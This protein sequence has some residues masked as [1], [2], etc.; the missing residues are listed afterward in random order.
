MTQSQ[1]KLPKECLL[2][3]IDLNSEAITEA[4]IKSFGKERFIP[5]SDI[6]DFNRE[7]VFLQNYYYS[8]QNLI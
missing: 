4:L 6:Q 7:E 3:K 5:L 8:L 1:Y 2:M